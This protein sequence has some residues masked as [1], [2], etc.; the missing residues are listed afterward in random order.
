M[1]SII[2]LTKDNNNDASITKLIHNNYDSDLL[3]V[4]NSCGV[5]KP[6]EHAVRVAIWNKLGYEI[7]GLSKAGKKELLAEIK[8]NPELNQFANE[9]LFFFCE[10]LKFNS[11]SILELRSRGFTVF[12][13]FHIKD[14]CYSFLFPFSSENI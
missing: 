4:I 10:S 8:N 12:K 11:R 5:A 13:N 9:I 1:T 7:P 2:G 14:F 6:L 3:F